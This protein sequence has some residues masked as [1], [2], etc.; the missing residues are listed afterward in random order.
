MVAGGVDPPRYAPGSGPL[1][2]VIDGAEPSAAQMGRSVYAVVRSR[3][4][5]P[6]VL[7]IARDVVGASGVH[8]VRP[9]L[10]TDG[11]RY[12]VM[13]FVDLDDNGICT[14]TDNWDMRSPFLVSG[15]TP[16]AL[17]LTPMG[18]QPAI[19]AGIATPFLPPGDVDGDGCVDVTDVG[20]LEGQL[21][22]A[23]PRLQGDLD[24]DGDVDADD[25]A[26]LD[27]HYCTCP[28]IF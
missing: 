24:R 9:S 23:G 4:N 10:V 22:M 3:T 8:I 26:V 6:M 7:D 28:G 21:G 16:V 25:I 20:I 18:I 11:D 14:G 15:S 13:V 19:C 5:P 12:D 1:Q 17:D 2:L 27:A